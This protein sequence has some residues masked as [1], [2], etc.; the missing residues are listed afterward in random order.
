MIRDYEF[1]ADLYLFKH[2]KI[3]VALSTLYDYFHE[4]SEIII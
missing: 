4:W 2:K 3:T 1:L